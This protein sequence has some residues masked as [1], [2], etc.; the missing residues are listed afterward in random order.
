V[1]LGGVS[2]QPDLHTNTAHLT[3]IGEGRPGGPV[4]W[5]RLI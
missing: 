1:R 2:N 5:M 3:L 4:P